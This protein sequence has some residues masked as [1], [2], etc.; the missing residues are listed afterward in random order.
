[1]PLGLLDL[2]FEIIIRILK[3]LPTETVK[4]LQDIPQLRQLALS[5]LYETVIIDVDETETLISNKYNAKPIS[6]YFHTG[7]NRPWTISY[8]QFLQ[9]NNDS[10][11]SFVKHIIIKDPE[12]LFH[13]REKFPSAPKDI[14][15]TIDFSYLRDVTTDVDVNCIISKCIELEYNIV[16]IISYGTFNPTVLYI[17]GR[18]ELPDARLMSNKEVLGIKKLVAFTNLTN[19][20]LYYAID[21]EDLHCIP[22][23][24][25][26]LSCS[27]MESPESESTRLNLP[28][29][30]VS[31]RISFEATDVNTS[32]YL[33]DISHLENLREVHSDFPSNLKLPK[34]LKS[35]EATIGGDLDQIINECPRLE[36]MKYN[37]FT[38]QKLHDLPS[39]LKVIEGAANFV[40]Y[41]INRA[42]EKKSDE[43]INKKQRKEDDIKVIRFPSMLERLKLEGWL[44][45][46]GVTREA[47][48][49]ASLDFQLFSNSESVVLKN[50]TNLDLRGISW[51]KRIGQFPRS[52]KRLKLC[53]VRGVNY[54]DLKNLSNLV[55]FILT[56]K[57]QDYFDYELPSSLLQLELLDCHFRTIKIYADNL[58]FLV[59]H[60]NKLKR[61]NDSSLCIPESVQE[62]DLKGNNIKRIELSF[63]FPKGL[64]LLSFMNESLT[65]FPKI[66]SSLKEFLFIENDLK[67]LNHEIKF[68]PDL[69]EIDIQ[70]NTFQCD[71]DFSKFNFS[72][73]TVLR[74]LRFSHIRF[75]ESSGTLNILLDK[76]PKSLISLEL[77]DSQANIIGNF[78]HFPN[79]EE[80][81][82]RDI[83]KLIG[84]FN[85]ID[86]ILEDVYLP[87][88]IKEI[89]INEDTFSNDNFDRFVNILKHKLNSEFMIGL[90]VS[91]FEGG[92]FNKCITYYK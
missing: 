82:L 66:P 68:P 73:C 23:S 83:N 37:G 14:N 51:L 47:L 72:A 62:L 9:M 52:L 16:K 3:L 26:H 29:G 18:T 56:D 28:M 4:R 63:R 85:I 22:K 54:H 38:Y 78:N 46:G 19:L 20:D 30:L 6:G 61:V 81:D 10:R 58:Q 55:Q 31:L 5:V 69:E 84:T 92:F 64:V 25:K 7:N 77:E 48:E 91:S 45:N 39:S 1:M 75:M 13:L 80:L 50:L 71:P 35:I 87:D 57:T 79:L 90:R 89:W 27:V 40:E 21:M 67:N 24:V 74:K 17:P 15:I 36:V 60:N 65:L 88:T 34:N 86:G 2:P 32:G 42:L 70:G 53:H 12:A 44:E 49:A 43:H 41:C 76:L 8:N 33:G 11:V 59:L